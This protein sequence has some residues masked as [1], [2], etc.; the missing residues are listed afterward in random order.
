MN[1]LRPLIDRFVE[2]GVIAGP[3]DEY[4]VEWSDLM[5]PSD[6]DKADVAKV[7]TE[8]I[9]TYTDS[10][11]AE[12]VIPLDFFLRKFLEL[13]TEEMDQIAEMIVDTAAEANGPEPPEP[14][15]PT[16]TDED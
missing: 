7:K 8:T 6:K 14:P 4:T 13:T 9:K 2:Y 11:G 5:T 16:E 10:L 3:K 12:D 1:L 15:E